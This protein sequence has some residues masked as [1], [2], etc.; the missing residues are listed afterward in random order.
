[1]KV[2][3]SNPYKAAGL[4]ASG[5]LFLVAIALIGWQAVCGSYSKWVELTERS[6]SYLFRPGPKYYYNHYSGLQFACVLA[7]DALQAL[8]LIERS[9]GQATGTLR[10]RLLRALTTMY[11]SVLGVS[12]FACA[13]CYGL[14]PK[15]DAT[16]IQALIFIN[17]LVALTRIFFGLRSREK[18]QNLERISSDA[19][20]NA[21]LFSSSIAFVNGLNRLLKFVRFVLSV[22][23]LAGAIQ[24]AMQYRYQN[25]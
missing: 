6:Q 18:Q 21:R 9:C 24:L 12:A 5:A 13:I 20:R 22:L 23:F 3:Y 1:M 4:S 19:N 11:W 25:P 8:R 15:P 10:T 7:F 16:A 14:T 17:S 2:V